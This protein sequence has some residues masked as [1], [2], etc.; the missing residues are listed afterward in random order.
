MK[1]A[2]MISFCREIKKVM[3]ANTPFLE[4]YKEF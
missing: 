4:F 3:K 1:M 2:K